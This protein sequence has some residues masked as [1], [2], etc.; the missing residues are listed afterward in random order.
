VELTRV[1][2]QQCAAELIAAAKE[3]STVRLRLAALR[4][5]ARWLVSEG[6][7]PEDQLLPRLWHSPWLTFNRSRTEWWQ[8]G[9]QGHE[10][11]GRATEPD[12][13]VL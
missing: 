13:Y 11:S 9:R 6:E 10:G 1:Q 2:I 4:Q 3:A 7:L 5:F 8:S 12:S